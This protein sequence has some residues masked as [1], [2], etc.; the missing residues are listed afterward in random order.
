M[1][2]VVVGNKRRTTGA[3]REYKSFFTPN[4]YRFSSHLDFREEPRQRIRADRTGRPPRI[5]L[6]ARGSGPRLFYDRAGFIRI[7]AYSVRK[8]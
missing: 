6:H 7:I 3:V 5:H 8:R 4:E 2:S 1:R